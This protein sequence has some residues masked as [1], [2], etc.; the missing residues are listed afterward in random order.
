[1]QITLYAPQIMNRYPK[2]LHRTLAPLR[3]LFFRIIESKKYG[4][5]RISINPVIICII[6]VVIILFVKNIISDCGIFPA[7]PLPRL[8]I[9]WLL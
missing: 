5:A 7:V 1:M 3:L 6:A 9:I 8:K 2:I 4:T